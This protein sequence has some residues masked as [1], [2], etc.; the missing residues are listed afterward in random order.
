VFPRCRGSRPG[1]SPSTRGRGGGAG[2]GVLRTAWKASV[3]SSSESASRSTTRASPAP[4]SGAARRRGACLPEATGHP[5]PGM[6]Q[7]IDDLGVSE[8]HVEGHDRSAG[9]RHREVGH[10]PLGPILADQRHALPG[11]QA[12]PDERAGHQAGCCAT[13]AYERRR[14]PVVSL[15]WRANDRVARRRLLRIARKITAA[16][17]PPVPP[18]RDFRAAC[19]IRRDR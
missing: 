13:S 8:L 3:R 5:T 11:R 12:R 2:V 14:Y 6:P 7:D 18:R 16:S 17:R 1:R 15:I 9:R 4:L 19:C 10:G